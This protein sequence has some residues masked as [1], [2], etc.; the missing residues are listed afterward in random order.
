MTKY[1]KLFFTSLIILLQFRF[2]HAADQFSNDSGKLYTV[3]A[4][5]V[6]ILLGIAFFLFYLERR[7]STI[8]KKIDEPEM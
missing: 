1:L 8:E 2:A 5:V 4:C 6:V 7:I 3:V